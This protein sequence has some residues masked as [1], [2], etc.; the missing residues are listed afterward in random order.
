MKKISLILLISALW[1]GFASAGQSPR[2][3]PGV[4][5]YASDFSLVDVRGNVIRLSDF[6]GKKSVA[7]IF[8]ADHG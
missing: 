1:V 4:G 8:Y 5:D 2:S 7:L 6:K 3:S